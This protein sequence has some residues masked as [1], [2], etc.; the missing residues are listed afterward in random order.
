[1]AISSLTASA[2][3]EHLLNLAGDVDSQPVRVGS[4]AIG[5]APHP[6]ISCS[7]LLVQVEFCRAH[8]S[9]VRSMLRSFIWQDTRTHKPY[10]FRG[11]A[12]QP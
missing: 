3:A 10:H 7:W 5:A 11:H 12:M 6:Q 1:M 2:L 4:M 8:F 9:R